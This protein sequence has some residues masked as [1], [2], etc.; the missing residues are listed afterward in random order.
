MKTADVVADILIA[1]VAGYL[2]T[3]VMGPVS[4]GLYKLE[5]DADRA[6]EDAVRPGPPYEMAAKK[7]LGALGFPVEGKTLERAG[8]VFHYGL[9]IGWAPTYTLLRRNTH[10]NP[11]AA[12]LLSGAAMSLLIDEGMT[13]MMGASAPDSAY[14]ASTHIRGFIAHLVFGVTVAAVTETAWTFSGR[15]PT[16]YDD[17]G[18]TQR[19]PSGTT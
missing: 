6:Q 10:I 9:A 19:D 8:M 13:P 4:M 2:A 11:L 16:H 12:G 14:P 17:P 18:A 5:S 7:T 15:R 3:Q 1:P